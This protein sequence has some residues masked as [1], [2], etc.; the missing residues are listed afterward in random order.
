MH[1]GGSLK[2][3]TGIYKYLLYSD[4]AEKSLFHSELHRKAGLYRRTTRPR[5]R[6]LFSQFLQ[7]YKQ[8]FKCIAITYS[9]MT[10]NL[11]NQF[12]SDGRSDFI[13]AFSIS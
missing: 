9:R 8:I 12:F 13:P 6:Q 2:I 10:K 11:R 1:G 4:L 3:R 7:T 5:T